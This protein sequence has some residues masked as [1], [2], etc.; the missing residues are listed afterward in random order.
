MHENI[1]KYFQVTAN[2]NLYTALWNVAESSI[3]AKYFFIMTAG[4]K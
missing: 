2:C 1:S 4:K 3:E